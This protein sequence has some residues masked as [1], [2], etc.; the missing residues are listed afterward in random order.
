MIPGSSTNSQRFQHD[1]ANR[2]VSARTDAGVVI[3]TYT[4]GASNERLIAEES[5]VRTYYASEGGTAIAEYTES[6]NSTT[7]VWSKSY[8]YL[9]DRLLSTLTPNG[10]GGDAFTYYHPDRLGTRLITTDAAS[11]PSGTS[12]Q[13]QLTLPFGTAFAETPAAAGVTSGG[14]N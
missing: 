7:P 3:A 11:N 1:A 14:T 5:G 9:G 4:Y 2:L 10:N 13:E 8:L 12:A 6:G